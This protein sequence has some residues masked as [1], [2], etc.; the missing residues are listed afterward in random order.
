MKRFPSFAFSSLGAMAIVAS[1]SCTSDPGNGGAFFTDV[2]ARSGIDFRF[3]NG[4]S[5]E[6]FVIETACGG[7]AWIDYDGDGF[8]DLFVT[9]GRTLPDRTGRR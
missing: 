2:T 9:G 1:A 4:S 5:G 6:R 3:V 7:L 8:P